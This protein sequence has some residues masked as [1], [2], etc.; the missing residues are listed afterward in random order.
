MGIKKTEIQEKRLYWLWL[1]ES[2][3]RNRRAALLRQY[4]TIEEIYRAYVLDREVSEEGLWLPDKEELLER[5][6]RY[7]QKGIFFCCC[8]EE[9]YPVCLKEIYSPPGGLYYRGR[10]PE[11]AGD[12][13]RRLAVVGARACSERGRA[14]ARRI[15]RELAEAG[16]G[17]VSGLALGIDGAA[18]QGAVE[19][20]GDVYG[21]LGCGV[22]VCYP[23]ENSR[24]F[25]QV[26]ERGG[27]LAEYPPGTSPLPAYFP[28][29]NRIISGLSDGVL[30]IE[31]RKRSG[32]LITAEFGLE[33]GRNI[34]AVPGRPEDALSEGC[35]H[36]IQNG[37]KLVTGVE[38]ILS[39][40]DFEVGVRLDS[41][42]VPKIL[43]ETTEKIVY[44]CLRL[45]PKHLGQIQRESGLEWQEVFNILLKLEL[46]GCAR[47]VSMDCYVAI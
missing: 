46:K 9:G 36:L 34:Y 39:D 25:G 27:I 2:G 5:L 35:H 28:Q 10:L 14:F 30:V 31:A 4:G 44:A 3:L 12:L 1:A 26:S 6:S 42:Q 15:G 43:L 32:S 45:E 20:G 29:R 16:S 23:K 17:V 22:D 11:P 18:L 7:E 37:A 24:L 13:S 8:E 47:Q 40:Y 21:V 38:D 19:A 41:G 33:Q